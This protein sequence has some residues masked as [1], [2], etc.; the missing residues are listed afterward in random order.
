MSSVIKKKSKS[1]NSV[2]NIDS[3]LRKHQAKELLRFVVIGSVDDGKSTL[4]GRLLY[5]T[6]NVYEDQLLA[7]KKATK[8]DLSSASSSKKS[9]KSKKNSEVIPD[10]DFSLITDGLKSEREQGITIDVA[11]RYFNTKNRKCIIA[12]TPGHIQYTRNMVT[13][14]STASAAIILIDARKGVLD[15]TRRHA[16]ISSLLG[17][18]RLIVAI[19]KMDLVD[20]QQKVF[21]KIKRDFENFL[22]TIGCNKHGMEISFREVLFIP[23]SALAGDNIVKASVHMPWY[24]N[25]RYGDNILSHLDTIPVNKN[26]PDQKS[27]QETADIFLPIQYVIRPD[28]NFRGYAGELISGKLTVGNVVEV[29]PSSKQSKIKSI[30]EN[31]DLVNTTRAPLSVVI[32]LEDE[33]DVSR[34]NIIVSP[35]TDC[36]VLHSFKADIV[37]I[38]EHTFHSKHRHKTFWLKHTTNLH[39]ATVKRIDSKLN[40]T[41]LTYEANKN[42]R[43]ELNDIG[44]VQIS[45]TSPIVCKSYQENKKAGAFILID[46]ISNLTIACG[47][48]R[49]YDYD[50]KEDIS[51]LAH[52]L[53]P[54]SRAKHFRQKPCLL[55]FTGMPGS[56]RIV[57]ARALEKKLLDEGHLIYVLDSKTISTS[58]IQPQVEMLLDAGFIVIIVANYSNHKQKNNLKQVIEKVKKIK[59]IDS[60]EIHHIIAEEKAQKRSTALARGK[61]NVNFDYHL[62]IDEKKLPSHYF[63]Q[64][65]IKMLENKTN[66]LTAM[67]KITT[68]LFETKCIDYSISYSNLTR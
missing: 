35:D 43:M 25:E 29:L 30:R 21:Q 18:P 48:M 62:G 46:K 64:E 15:Q 45:L 61:I 38:N 10:L 23:I 56:G 22:T 3:L 7:V 53:T 11:Y 57:L 36:H 39:T 37:W 60:F 52:D 12:D 54:I 59:T 1:T 66:R 32:T 68:K 31:G 28:M 34:G 26:L 6:D 20:Y 9:P 5:E 13:G 17:I 67:K 50:E 42:D 47:M 24:K 44:R 4:I 41:T 27:S 51:V 16:A 55:I 49:S 14:A 8:Q 63:I 40:L 33:I 2:K 58:V 65:K 19:N